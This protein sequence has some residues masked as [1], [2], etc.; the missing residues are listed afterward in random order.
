MTT[1]RQIGAP[2]KIGRWRSPVLG[3]AFSPDGKILAT[4][5]GNGDVRL[6]HVTTGR[7]IGPTMYV[8]N[9]KDAKDVAFSPDGRLLAAVGA[10]G[11]R[12]WSVATQNPISTPIS[13]LG[14]TIRYGVDAL[15]FSPDGKVIATAGS[16]GTVRLWDVATE[17]QIG[18]TMHAGS[19]KADGVAFTPDGKTLV[20]TDTDGT[21]RQ[22]SVATH[23][24]IGPPLA[25][26]DHHKFGMA[27]V[28][29]AGTILVTIQDSGPA[30]LW[31]LEF[32]SQPFCPE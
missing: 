23:H 29:P 1:G 4:A 6:W 5:S 28:S 32:A 9:S 31:N 10:Y 18:T 24:P 7:Q 12:L 20:T 8:T 11:T 30:C 21:I 26:G 22:W 2:I 17:R 27:A 16:D 14:Q 13:G 3:V 15:A 25:A 19:A